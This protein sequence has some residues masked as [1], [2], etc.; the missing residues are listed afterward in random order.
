MYFDEDYWIFKEPHLDER[1]QIKFTGQTQTVMDNIFLWSEFY[2]TK[3]EKKRVL[4]FWVCD[5]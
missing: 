2:S 5:E 3:I 4:H 1:K